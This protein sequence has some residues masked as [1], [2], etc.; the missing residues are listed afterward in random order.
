MIAVFLND[1]AIEYIN[2]S[3]VYY[4]NKEHDK[5]LKLCLEGIKLFPENDMILTN[6][7]YAATMTGKIDE[8][9]NFVTKESSDP[10]VVANQTHA[11]QS[12]G[13]NK[14]AYELLIRYFNKGGKINADF[15]VNLMYSCCTYSIPDD[16]TVD[17][18]ISAAIDV[19]GNEKKII[20]I[21]VLITNLVT[22]MGRTKRQDGILNVIEL[23]KKNGYKM[24]GTIY[25][26]YTYGGCLIKDMTIKKMILDDVIGQH[27]KNPEM[28][29]G[30][31]NDAYIILGNI[32]VIYGQLGDKK[33]M[34]EYLGLTKKYHPEFIKLKT[35]EDFKDY[36]N[37]EDFL[38]MFD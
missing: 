23:Y 28:I 18:I 17:K 34:L 4:E 37:D 6:I 9:W 16:N 26:N 33:K 3:K 13:K 22:I 21:N 19:I 11:L 2:L 1:A 36:W 31:K 27:K 25:C 12:K 8:V 15:M 14:E 24:N 5:M 35:E 7:I 29:I 20:N 30:D 10:L 38:N 32:A